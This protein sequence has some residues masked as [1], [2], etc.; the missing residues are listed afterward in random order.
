MICLSR[1]EKETAL[2]AQTLGEKLKKGD[3]VLLYGELGAGKSVFARGCARALGVTG[4]MASPS[5]TLMQSYRGDACSVNHFDLYRL[6][7]P[8]ELYYAGLEEQIG[9][10]A[11]SLI[12][13]PQQADVCPDRRVEVDIE[14]ADAYEARRIEIN[15]FGMEDRAEE[16][17][18]ALMRFKAEKTN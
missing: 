13:W 4:D 3:T 8:D 11:V 17:Y 2:I 18:G 10:D 7:G 5:F 12:E 16:I 1:S 15:L 6:S 14:R 9:A